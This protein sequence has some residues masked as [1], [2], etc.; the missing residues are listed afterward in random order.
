MGLR[1]LKDHSVSPTSKK[2]GTIFGGCG[3]V[4][5]IGGRVGVCRY[6]C[7]DRG[8]QSRSVSGISRFR[9]ADSATVALTSAVG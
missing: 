7:L 1:H 8:L 2:I 5:G 4:V 3:G 9:L 6:V